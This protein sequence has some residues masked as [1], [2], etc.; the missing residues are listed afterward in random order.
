MKN[1]WKLLRTL[2]VQVVDMYRVIRMHIVYHIDISLDPYTKDSGREIIE[3]VLDRWLGLMVLYIK[4]NGFKEKQ[5]VRANLS[6]QMEIVTKAPGSMIKL[7]V[8]VFLK[9]F[10]NQ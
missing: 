7:M 10:K 8:G 9:N 4:G 2:T 5:K 3:M 1:I 6:M